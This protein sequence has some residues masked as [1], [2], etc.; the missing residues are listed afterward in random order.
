MSRIGKKPIIIPKGVTIQ[1]KGQEIEVKGPSGSLTRK[2]PQEIGVK[3]DNGQ[4]IVAPNVDKT[5]E[6]TPALFGLIRTLIDNM[7]QGVVHPWKKDLE[8]QGVG[9]RASKNGQILNLQLCYS[10]PID[11]KMPDSIQYSSQNQIDEA[12]GTL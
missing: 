11:F 7:V 10:H 3:V 5:S 4:I 12:S 9:Y 1:I 8:I 6:L 2:L